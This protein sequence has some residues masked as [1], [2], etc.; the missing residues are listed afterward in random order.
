MATDKQI[1]TKEAQVQITLDRRRLGTSMRKILD[2]KL[3]PEAEIKKVRYSG[4][5]RTTPDLDVMGYSFSFKTHGQDHDWWLSVWNEIQSA[6]EQG[7][8]MPEIQIAVV[9]NYRDGI[10]TEAINLHG[11]MVLKLDDHEHPNDDYISNSWSGYCQ[12]AE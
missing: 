10:T 7:F 6:E 9:L 8:P 12:F 1:R 4:E 11:Q 3:T 5:K 2:F